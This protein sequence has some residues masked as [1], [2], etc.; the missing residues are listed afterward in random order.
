MASAA[1]IGLSSRP[2]DGIQ[3]AR[4]DRHADDVV[5]EGEE[6]V[7]PDV[8]HRRPAE[9]A[10]R[11]R[12]RAR[13]PFTSVTPALCIATSVPVPIAMPT[14]A[15]ASA[16]ASLTPSPAMA[17]TWPCAAGAGR[18]RSCP[19]AAPRPATS[20]MP[21][22]RATASA[23]VRLS[24]V[25]MTIAD[26]SARRR[27]SAAAV[28][29]LIGSATA[30]TPAGLPSTATNSAVAPSLPQRL[31]LRG[32]RARRRRRAPSI[33]AALPSATARPSTVPVTPLPVIDAKPR[34]GSS[35]S[36]ALARRRDDGA[37]RADARSPAPG[38][39]RAAAG[40]LLDD[41]RRGNDRDHARLALGQRAGLVDDQRVDLLHPL[42]RLGDLDQHAGRRALAD[43]DHDRHR[44]REAERAGA[45][46]DQ[47]GHRGDQG[48]GERGAG[49]PDRPGDERH[50]R[51]RDHRRH[52]PAATT[53]GEA[54]DRRAACAAPRA[55]MRDD[56][57]QHG[58]RPD[59]LGAHDERAGAVHRAADEPVA[60]AA[61]PP[62]WT[63]R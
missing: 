45:G 41:A 2:N 15:A 47:H 16:G 60:G 48:V 7:L 46:D 19:R 4:G 62:A 9:R 36:A 1:T 61:S 30:T 20:S 33:S 32:Q 55:T 50:E 14:S 56:A 17:T 52:E 34:L 51:D 63:R 42:Q 13:S 44:R 57:R 24:P 43:A 26:A 11:A 27:A 12:C 49:S 3:H 21:S 35:G 31:G 29:A 22:V 37:R 53:V 28:V 25:S 23:V 39:P 58:V 8:A 18:L 5:D 38:W 40:R 59:P 54:L 6:Q 10:A